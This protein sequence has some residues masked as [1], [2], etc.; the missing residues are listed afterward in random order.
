MDIYYGSS[1]RIVTLTLTLLGLFIILY[2][3]IT[4]AQRGA[5]VALLDWQNTSITQTAIARCVRQHTRLAEHS[6]HTRLNILG[7]PRG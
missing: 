5:A 4:T 2:R 1:I 7:R 6:E 3:D